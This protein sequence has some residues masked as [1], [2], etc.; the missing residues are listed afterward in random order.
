MLEDYTRGDQSAV[1]SWVDHVL[2][3]GGGLVL[4][5]GE[6]HF[7]TTDALEGQGVKDTLINDHTYLQGC[8]QLQTVHSSLHSGPCPV[9]LLC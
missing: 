7:A 9:D 2:A 6:G 1:L 8:P 4:V 3:D 5:L